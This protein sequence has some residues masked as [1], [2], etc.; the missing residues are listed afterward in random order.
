MA[1]SQITAP[2]IAAFKPVTA[3]LMRKYRDNLQDCRQMQI[4]NHMG[5]FSGT[6]TSSS[7]TTLVTLRLFIPGCMVGD[8][9]VRLTFGAW[10]SGTSNSRFTIVVGATTGGPFLVA[11]TEYYIDLPNTT[12]EGIYDVEFKARSVGGADTTNVD[13]LRNAYGRMTLLE[14]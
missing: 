10:G 7:A 14:A 4:N 3:R 8:G 9:G 6:T 1:W 11:D 5:G 13:Y 12:T 2:E